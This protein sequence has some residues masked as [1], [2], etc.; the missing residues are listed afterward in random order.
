MSTAQ[1]L[2]TLNYVRAGCYYEALIMSVLYVI[3]PIYCAL[4]MSMLYVT[5]YI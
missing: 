5:V 1:Q 3:R 2:Y 4:I